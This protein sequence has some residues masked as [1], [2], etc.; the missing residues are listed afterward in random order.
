MS[1]YEGIVLAIFGL[2]LHHTLQTQRGGGGGGGVGGDR[3]SGPT[4]TNYKK[5][6]F[7]RNTGPDPLKITKLLSQHLMLGH[8]WPASETPFKWCF[9]GGPFMAR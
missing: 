8:N 3:G 6:G 4:Q 1:R 2:I 9:V 5:I 7:L